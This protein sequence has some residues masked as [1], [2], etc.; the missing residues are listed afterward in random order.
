MAHVTF[1]DC[2]C[3]ANEMHI[4]MFIKFITLFY[5]SASYKK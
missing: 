4:E 1:N 5:W 3:F 2:N